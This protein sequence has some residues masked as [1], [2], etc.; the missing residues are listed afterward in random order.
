MLVSGSRGQM[1]PFQ[2]MLS[3][4]CY[5]INMLIY[6][7]YFK[8]VLFALGMHTF[9]NRYI[10]LPDE[11]AAC[12][13]EIRSNPKLYPYF[14]DIIGALD[15]THIQSCPSAAQRQAAR[16]RKGNVSQNCLAACNFAMHFLYMVTG[17][18]GSATD[19]T[20][21]NH[22]HLH[23]FQIPTGK[24]YLADA[25][26]EICETLLVPYHSVRYHLAEWG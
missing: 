1:K 20:I 12:P 5:V 6:I 19:G 7:R 22:A 3:L 16:D 11:D 21:Y 8:E 4:D 25:G 9:Y 14:K 15:G 23:D 24:M 17:W 18:E 2:S 26:F 13:P 10:S